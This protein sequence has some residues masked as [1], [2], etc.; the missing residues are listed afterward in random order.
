[1]DSAATTPRI[2]AKTGFCH[3]TRM[4]PYLYTVAFWISAACGDLAEIGAWSLCR[5]DIKKSADQSAPECANPFCAQ[6]QCCHR[7]PGWHLD[8]RDR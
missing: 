6:Q 2:L 3:L 1:M 5:Y 4:R 8:Y 7:R